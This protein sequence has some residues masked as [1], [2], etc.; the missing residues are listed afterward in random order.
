[1]R[2]RCGTNFFCPAFDHFYYG[3]CRNFQSAANTG[4]GWQ[5]VFIPAAGGDS[6]ETG[7]KEHEAMVH[8]VGMAALFLLMIVV[9]VQDVT[10]IFY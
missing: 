10:R 1:V 5:P 8:F 7:Q 9:T 6:A 4:A 3:Q 2:N